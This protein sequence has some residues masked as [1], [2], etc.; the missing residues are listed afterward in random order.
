MG[1][2]LF[3][4]TTNARAH[5][6]SDVRPLLRSWPGPLGRRTHVYRGTVTTVPQRPSP[7]PAWMAVPAAGLLVAAD[8]RLK[9]WA[10]TELS[11]GQAVAPLVPGWIEWTLTFNTGA[12]WSLFSGLTLPLA[13]G[14]L[15]F[16]L[17]ALAFLLLRPQPLLPLTA[18]SLIATGALGNAIDG[19]RA[20]RV[21]DMIASPAL[22]HWSRLAGSD[23]F[24][25]F[26]LA[27][28][29]VV[30]GVILLLGMTVANE[31]N[32]HAISR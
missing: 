25:V 30:T 9:G 3:L 16:G 14:R 31:R 5:S 27:D 4:V 17:G 12:A 19:L 22:D 2:S 32:A 21:T 7:V 28:V 26:N 13:I 11:S 18:L 23:R 6:R 20:G 29:F 15:L 1:A 24:P 10:L 8:Q